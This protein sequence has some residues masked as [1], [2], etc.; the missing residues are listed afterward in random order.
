MSHCETLGTG[1]SCLI[2][3]LWE[4]GDHNFKAMGCSWCRGLFRQVSRLCYDA[5]VRCLINIC[6]SDTQVKFAVS[7]FLL[8]SRNLSTL[9]GQHLFTHPTYRQFLFTFALLTRPKL[10]FPPQEFSTPSQHWPLYIRRDAY[11]LGVVGISITHNHFADFL[12]SVDLSAPICFFH[13][14]AIFVSKFFELGVHDHYT[15]RVF[16]SQ[17]S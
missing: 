1:G 8:L 14:R 2:A 3:R 5:Q 12:L 15:T 13:E 10:F 6:I 17:L 4:Q 9:H 16:A 11:F 7:S